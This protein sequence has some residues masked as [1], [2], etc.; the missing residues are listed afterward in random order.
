MSHPQ[1]ILFTRQRWDRLFAVA[2][3]AA[4]VVGGICGYLTGHVGYCVVPLAFIGMWAYFRRTTPASGSRIQ[5]I[6][7]NPWTIR[8]LFWLGLNLVWLLCF[9]A[10]DTILLKNPIHGPLHWYHWLFLVVTVTI[11]T[12]GCHLI[13]RASKRLRAHEESDEPGDALKSRSQAV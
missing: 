12:T 4:G 3:I 10:F 13:D 6:E 7:G 9:I 5:T 1:T 8:L 2:T 11:M